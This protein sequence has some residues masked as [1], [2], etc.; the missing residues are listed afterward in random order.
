M[1]S[2]DLVFGEKI[3]KKL[4]AE[5]G[6]KQRS[7]VRVVQLDICDE[8]SCQNLAALLKAEHGGLDVLVNNAGF[9]FSNNDESPLVHQAEVTLEINYYGTKRISDT[10]IPLIRPRI[11]N[12]CSQAGVLR[13]YYSDSII[14][15]ISSPTTTYENIDRFCQLYKEHCVNG[16]YSVSKAAEIALTQVQSRE[17]KDRRIRVVSCCPGSVATK[18]TSFKGLFTPERGADTSAFLA[19]APP[20]SLMNGGFYYLRKP[21]EWP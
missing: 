3:L 16:A 17:L 21:I 18:M 2:R 13:G 15:L 4:R 9:A 11:V 1:T 12:V 6:E 5:V 10:L 19:V 7:E 8:E 20:M 14:E